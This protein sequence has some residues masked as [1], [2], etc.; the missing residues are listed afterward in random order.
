[1]KDSVANMLERKRGLERS[2]K[3]LEK[4]IAR[5]R[6]EHEELCTA[7]GVMQRF[8]V[9]IDESPMPVP[10]GSPTTIGDMALVVLKGH[11][12]GLTAS[13]ILTEIQER[14]KPDLARTSLSPPLSRLKEK[15]EI[16]YVESSGVWRISP[17]KE[18]PSVSTPEPS[19]NFEQGDEFE[20]EIPF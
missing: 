13:S 16:E 4:R 3:T 9:Q 10:N 1:M 8:G 7:I 6:R 2:L 15:K 14:W 12:E 11:S 18:G 5:E 19:T 17:N 20:E